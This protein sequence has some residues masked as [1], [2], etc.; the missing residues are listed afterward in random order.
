ME[1]KGPIFENE[2]IL[3]QMIN[4]EV[5][6]AQRARKKGIELFW[7]MMEVDDVTPN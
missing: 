7:T 6:K 4:L 3:N 2:K 1:N 5:K